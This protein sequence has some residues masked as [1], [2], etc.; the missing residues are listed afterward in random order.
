MRKYRVVL[1]N[2]DFSALEND[3]IESFSSFCDDFYH[4]MYINT[5]LELPAN[6]DTVL[7]FFERI[8]KQYPSMGNFYRKDSGDFCLE[9]DRTSGSWRHVTLEMDRLCSGNA[10]PTSFEDAY[11]LHLLV[12]ELAPY[13]LGVSSLDINSLDLTFAMDFAYNGN[14]DEVI[15]DALLAGSSFGTLLE[16]EG[17]R[18]TGFSPMV[19]IALEDD[20]KLQ[21]RIAVESR[22]TLSSQNGESGRTNEPISLYFTVRRYPRADEK[23]DATASLRQLSSVAEDMMIDEIIPNF[24][25]PLSGAIAQRR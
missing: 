3:M 23:F 14:H 19:T 13:M 16:K 4:D 6:R 7:T 8:R 2:F 10:N 24:V 21:A 5:E 22:T 1:L 17:A 12:L 11:S 9:G 15:A 20:N 25:K 18:A